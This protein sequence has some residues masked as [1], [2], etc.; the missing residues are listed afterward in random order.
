MKQKYR[1]LFFYTFLLGFLISAP[2]VLLYTAGY[3]YHPTLGKIVKTGVVSV[4]SIPKNATISIDNERQNLKTPA[5]IDNVYAT[6]HLIRV[7]KEDYLPW[8]K[9]VSVASNQTTFVEDIVLFLDARSKLLTIIDI[10]ELFISPSHL[11]T[12]YTIKEGS[13]REIWSL[14]K[15]ENEPILLARIPASFDD[16]ASL[17][18]SSKE[19]YLLLHTESEDTNS[20]AVLSTTKD[21]TITL[22][23]EDILT[24]WWDIQNESILYY[25]TEE[26]LVS[27]DITNESKTVLDFSAQAVTSA[28][29]GYFIISKNSEKTTLAHYT[30][31]DLTTLTYLPLGE[32][33]FLTAPSDVLFL[34]EQSH[35]RILLIDPNNAS[36]PILLNT[37]ATSW[38]WWGHYDLLYSDGYSLSRYNTGTKTTDTFL[39]LSEKITDSAWHP[40]GTYVFYVQSGAISVIELDDRDNVNTYKLSDEQNIAGIWMDEE[41]TSLHYFGQIDEGHY[42]HHERLLDN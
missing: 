4:T 20:Y 38:Q 8:E 23:S 1:Q 40:F 19:R 14:E 42:G 17:A 37:P 6:D 2:L 33:V 3:R 15:D 9:T 34:H 21:D 32:Y 11:R 30:Q 29:Q 41:A 12:V 36:N 28:D 24:A 10:T 35:N 7:E 25:Q 18:W 31:S 5:T 16:T 26:K 39:R 13:Y 27:F 22:E